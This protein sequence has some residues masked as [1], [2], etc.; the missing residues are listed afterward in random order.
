MMNVRTVH[1]TGLTADEHRQIADLVRATWPETPGVPLPPAL[2]ASKR[3]NWRPVQDHVLVM[4]GNTLI[5][6]AATFPKTLLVGGGELE[7]LGLAAVCVRKDRRGGGFGRQAVKQA[8]KPVDEGRYSVVLFQTAVPDFYRKLG[9]VEIANPFRNSTDRIAPDASP[10]W[11]PHV[12][13]YPDWP[14]WPEDPIDLN[15]PGY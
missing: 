11:D 8:L 10:W 15:G 5:A 1:D 13:I 12:M 7:V 6:H 3:S 9:A 14:G 2:A 4:D